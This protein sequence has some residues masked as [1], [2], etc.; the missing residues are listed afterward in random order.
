M[1]NQQFE[2]PKT[3]EEYEK[4]NGFTDTEEFYTN[5]ARLI[6]SFRVEQWLAHINQKT[7]MIDKSNFD[8][9]QYRADLQTAFECGQEKYKAFCEWV[10]G[11]VMEEEKWEGY[12]DS[13]AEIACRKLNKLGIVDKQGD[14]WVYK[15]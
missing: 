13:F 14:Y 5:G 1:G 10:A 8:L 2:F 6:P 12:K 9:N 11:E 3:W 7:P 15:E 4:Q